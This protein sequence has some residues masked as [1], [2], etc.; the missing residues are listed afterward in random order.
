MKRTIIVCVI[1]ASVTL[2]V[3]WPVRHQQF[4]NLD[5]DIYVTDNPHVVTG[6][7]WQNVRWAF[8]A[9]RGAHWFPMT[10]LSH[11]LDCQLFGLN[12]GAHKL[13][14]VAFHAGSVLILFIFLQRATGKTWTSA[15]AAAVF[16]VHPLRV[17][18]VAW[19]TE[20]KDVLSVFFWMLTMWAYLRYVE[21][22]GTAR[23]M[24]MLCFFILGLMSKPM[25]VTLPFALLLLD[26]WPL[27]RG[28]QVR[29]KLPLFALAT[30]AAVAQFCVTAHAGNISS[31]EIITWNF[32]LKNLAVSYALYLLKMFWPHNLAVL[33]SFPSEQPVLRVVGAVALLVAITVATIQARYRRPYLL[34]SWL[35]FL[36]TLLPVI[37]VVHAAGLVLFADRYTYIPMIGVV[38]GAIRWAAEATNRPQFRL[39][40][41]AGALVLLAGCVVLTRAQLS[42]WSDSETLLRRTLAVSPG[43]FLAESNLGVALSNRG[44]LEEAIAH[45][46]NA[47]QQQPRYAYAHNHLGRAYFSVGRIDEAIAHLREAV[48]LSPND[49]A[50]HNNLGLALAQEGRSEE[51][52][53]EFTRAVRLKPDYALAHANLGGVLVSLGKIEEALPHLREAVRLKPDFAEAQFNL[54]A[55]LA[56]QGRTSEARE[57][58]DLAVKLDPNLAAARR[59][60]E[61]KLQRTSP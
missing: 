22:P 57:H 51:A 52:I 15:F 37:G 20:R 33:A 4:V 56:Q 2:A 18:S 49:A 48:E 55:A 42:Y 34:V 60:L 3:F 39:P 61:E 21:R 32:R 47:V 24:W 8:T 10:W 53:A 46:Q 30:V 38:I 50:G 36:G 13:V 16:A 31:T 27:R 5:D 19:V 9:T 6:L 44:R 26:I 54:G 7:N 58:L 40:V 12:A 14:N 17:E 25:V 41:A 35:W 43:N 59:S 23:Y 28:W 45:L 1:L 29:E 11:M